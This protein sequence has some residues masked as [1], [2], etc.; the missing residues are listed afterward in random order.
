MRLRRA[1]ISGGAFFGAAYLLTFTACDEEGTTEDGIVYIGGATDEALDALLAGSA[2]SDSGKAVTFEA[3]TK[4]EVIPG[5]EPFTFI[6]SE[7]GAS[8][9]LDP[10]HLDPIHFGPL[11][12]ERSPLERALGVA[13]QG[14]R[15]AHAHGDPISG[16]AYYLVFSSSSDDEIVRVFTTNTDYTPGQDEWGKLRGA[17]GKISLRLTWADFETNRVVEGGGPWATPAISFTIQ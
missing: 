4:D 12:R 9:R 7:A 11:E 17:E 8:A 1:I 14:T 15:S 3:P 13:L 6:W 10:S 5:D 16:V 2:K